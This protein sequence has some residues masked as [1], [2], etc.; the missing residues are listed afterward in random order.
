MIAL[1][2]H[3]AFKNGDKYIDPSFNYAGTGFLIQNGQDTFA[4][5]A[6]HILWVARNKHSNSVQLNDA[7]SKWIMKPKHAESD[8]VII[9]KLINEDPLEVLTGANSTILERDVLVFS[10]RSAT[11]GLYILKPRYSNVVAGEKVFIVGYPYSESQMQVLETRVLRKL[12]TD[13]LIEQSPGKTVAGFSGSP[14]IDSNGYVVGIFSA[15]SSDGNKDVY[16]AISTE[17]LNDVLSRK[18]DLNKP[19][20]DYGALLLQTVLTKGTASAIKQYKGLIKEPKNFYI[21]NLRSSTTNGLREA[22]EKLID[23]KRYN[24]AIDILRFNATVNSAYFH[25]YNLLAKAWL[26]AGNKEEA[27]RNY[28]I[29]TTKLDNRSENPAF[30][31]LEKLDGR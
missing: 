4:V 11:E 2:N 27:I 5:T 16:V 22:G 13:I 24:D 7:L 6:K 29:S 31:E 3:V 18:P 28:K 23:M 10:V 9:N 8:S 15:A 17:Y 21:Y 20:Q 19:K 26:L 30:A 14:I 1:T 25:H 12:G